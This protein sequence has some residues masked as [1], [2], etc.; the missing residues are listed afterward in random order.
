MH[1][2]TD[3]SYFTCLLYN[4]LIHSSTIALGVCNKATVL[5]TKGRTIF[6]VQLL[7]STIVGWNVGLKFFLPN[8][9]AILCIGM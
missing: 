6:Q 2:Y 5:I 1:F 4:Y 7:D 3:F 8:I 9:W